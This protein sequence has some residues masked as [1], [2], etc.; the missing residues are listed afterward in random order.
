M[1]SDVL[2]VIRTGFG[3]TIQDLGRGGWRRFGVPPS[4][5][6]D[7]HS[8]VWGNRLLN[9]PP[10]AAVLELLLQGAAFAALQDTWVVVT[11]ADVEANLP[12][13][14]AVRV[15]RG[16]VIEFRRV[17]AGV[18]GYLA[19]EGGFSTR[20][21][22]G[23]G[24]AYPR[25][26]MGQ[27]LK[28]GDR[29]GRASMQSFELGPGVATRVVP[30]LERRDYLRLPALRVWLGPQAGLFSEGDRA[31]FFEQSW[32]VSAQSD[33]VGYRLV[34]SPLRSTAEQI[35]SEPVRIGTIQVPAGGEPIVTMRDGP[36][37]GGYP[38]LGVLESTDVSW[39]A[40]CRPGQSVRFRLA[41]AD[42]APTDP[43]DAAAIPA[44]GKDGRKV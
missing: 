3:V 23:S 33:R 11:G 17:R 30:P 10:G 24:S 2:E 9:N 26:G 35:L 4:G 18:W 12:L 5:A 14:R 25:G 44:L 7:Q 32:Q 22:L 27:F 39:M 29:L 43:D 38:K 20:K 21:F 42:F 1:G 37:V 19:I 6:M 16:D 41:D 28:V 40:Q 36:T 15:R 8:S 31:Q 34:G 13:W